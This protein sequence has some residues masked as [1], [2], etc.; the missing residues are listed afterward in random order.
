MHGNYFE[1]QLHFLKK[2][3]LSSLHINAEKR[4]KKERT[5]QDENHSPQGTDGET[6][7]H[8]AEHPPGVLKASQVKGLF[9][10]YTILASVNKAL[11]SC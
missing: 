4:L 1:G 8:E 3:N 7:C 6:L 2:E 5:P 11:L 10:F 9:C